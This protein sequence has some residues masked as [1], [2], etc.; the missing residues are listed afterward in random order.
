MFISVMSFCLLTCLVIL[1]ECWT[2]CTNYYKSSRLWYLFPVKNWFYSIRELKDRHRDEY[3]PLSYLVASVTNTFEFKDTSNQE[4]QWNRE[5]W[6]IVINSP[7]SPSLHWA[8]A[9]YWNQIKIKNSPSFHR[10][11]S[12]EPCT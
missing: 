5:V 9:V 12:F 10:E 4:A 7:D 1:F 6:D 8:C 11:A 3:Y 2:L